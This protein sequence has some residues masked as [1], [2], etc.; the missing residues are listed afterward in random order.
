MGD[1]MKLWYRPLIILSLAWAAGTF[2]RFGLSFSGGAPALEPII[3]QSTPTP[4]YDPLVTPDLPENPSQAEMGKFLYYFHC[5]P[6]HGDLGQGLTDEFRQVWV[7]DHQNCWERGCHGGRQEDEGFPIPTVVPMVI[8]DGDALIRFQA[9]D[10]L[11]IYLH[12]THPPQYPG[13]LAADEYR[14]LTAFL[15]EANHKPFRPAASAT[16]LAPEAT[17]TKEILPTLTSRP[18]SPPSPSSENPHPTQAPPAGEPG[19]PFN[20]AWVVAGL[21]A[22][23]L[24][25][26]SLTWI[27]SRRKP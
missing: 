4:T 11:E 7:E 17:A 16:S 14:D 21:A 18:P 2:G 19:L 13:K 5:M 8:S 9:F 22:G 23:T 27:V 12:D 20:L 3:G 1:Q 6:C 24:A 25:V 10:A 15:W 26:F